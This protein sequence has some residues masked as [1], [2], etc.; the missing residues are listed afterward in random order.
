MVPPI[1]PVGIET[2]LVECAELFEFANK[3]LVAKFQVITLFIQLREMYNG[4]I[5]SKNKKV[6]S[7]LMQN[8]KLTKAAE[9]SLKKTWKLLKESGEDVGE[10]EILSIN[11]NSKAA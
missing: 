2:I 6:I 1:A 5:S 9:I 11:P 10:E 7:Y 8:E 3:N 4:F